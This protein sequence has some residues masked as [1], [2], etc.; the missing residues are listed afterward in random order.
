[1]QGLKASLAEKDGRIEELENQLA[2][3]KNMQELL[4][5]K[6]LQLVTVEKELFEMND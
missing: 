4:N 2:E 1:M 5:E 6:K 3:Q